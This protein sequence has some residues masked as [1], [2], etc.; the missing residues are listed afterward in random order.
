MVVV[1]T[2]LAR[3]KLSIYQ[4]QSPVAPGEPCHHHVT[5]SNFSYIKASTGRCQEVPGD[6]RLWPSN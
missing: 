6:A 5:T 3:L 4:T 2:T 1:G